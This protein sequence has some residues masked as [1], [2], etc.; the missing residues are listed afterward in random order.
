MVLYTRLR[1][2]E[3][4]GEIWPGKKILV[5]T[6]VYLGFANVYL[7]FTNVYLNFTNI[8]LSFSDVYLGFMVYLG[9]TKVTWKK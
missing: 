8:Y 2:I 7:N 9:K 5:F 1:T 4:D 3:W 6:H